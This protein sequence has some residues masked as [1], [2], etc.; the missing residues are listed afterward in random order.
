M[1]TRAVTILC[2]VQVATLVVAWVL[3]SRFVRVAERVWE[4]DDYFWG[5]DTPLFRWLQ[6]YRDWGVALILFPAALTALCARL[7]TCHR[8]LA[9]LGEGGFRIV[10]IATVCCLGFAAFVIWGSFQCAFGPRVVT[11]I[12]STSSFDSKF[13]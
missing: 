7:T 2:L 5:F 6:R 4:A 8:E 11:L 12:R 3:T 13:L 9:I 1:P 10:L